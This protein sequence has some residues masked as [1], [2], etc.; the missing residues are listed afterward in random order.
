MPSQRL[1]IVRRR[2]AAFWVAVTR[3]PGKSIFFREKGR[4]ARRPHGFHRR[5][6]PTC[7]ETPNS[8]MPELPLCPSG[9][10]I[11]TKTEQLGAD[12]VTMLPETRQ[13]GSA[14]P[15]DGPHTASSVFERRLVYSDRQ[16]SSATRT[17]KQR[18]RAP[19]R[20]LQRFCFNNFFL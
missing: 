17:R 19:C 3:A 7:P 18:K 8:Y 2:G 14:S 12:F 15:N 20:E 6:G 16:Y 5:W 4:V 1:I 11:A 9:T 10:S 13:R